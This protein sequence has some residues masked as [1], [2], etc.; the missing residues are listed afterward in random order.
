MITAL[1]IA[2]AA[3]LLTYGVLFVEPMAT[4]TSSIMSLG[5]LFAIRRGWLPTRN[6]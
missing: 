4:A 5:T 1:L 3:G 6:K 2:F